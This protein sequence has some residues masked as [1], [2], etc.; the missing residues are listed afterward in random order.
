MSDGK[1]TY[2]MVS[3]NLIITWLVSTVILLA[4][5]LVSFQY[6]NYVDTRSNKQ[7]CGIVNLF[8]DTYKDSPPP[9]GRGQTLADEFIKLSK[10]FSCN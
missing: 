3:R 8:N 9:P 1:P 7:W 4:L 10:K 5:V 6:T 2:V